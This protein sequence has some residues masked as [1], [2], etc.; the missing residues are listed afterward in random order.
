M[1]MMYTPEGAKK[2]CWRFEHELDACLVDTQVIARCPIRYNAAGNCDA[3]QKRCCTVFLLLK[4]PLR[5]VTP[6]REIR[7]KQ[8]NRDSLRICMP[9][10]L[11]R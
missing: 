2:D 9:Y 1:S 4:F 11:R 6:F 8:H 3:R 10:P 5:M 7:S